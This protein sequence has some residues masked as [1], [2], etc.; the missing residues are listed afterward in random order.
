MNG[1]RFG[2]HFADRTETDLQF[3]RFREFSTVANSLF[4][5]AMNPLKSDSNSTLRDS[6]LIDV[7]VPF[8]SREIVVGLLTS[9][10]FPF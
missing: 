1:Q 6:D 9:C 10:G 7:K 5:T 3:H 4:V 8:N 2:I